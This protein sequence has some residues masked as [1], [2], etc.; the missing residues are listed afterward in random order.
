[1]AA[2]GLA[3][4]CGFAPGLP[5][6]GVLGGPSVASAAPALLCGLDPPRGA[7]PAADPL[8]SALPLIAAAAGL[9]AGASKGS[10]GQGRRARRCRRG[11]AAHEAA[12]L[13][14]EQ[15][16]APS[17][18][19]PRTAARRHVAPNPI[20]VSLWHDVDLQPKDWLDQLTGLL[21]YVNE[22]P[23]GTLQK[24]E[25]Q[26]GEPMN[27]ITEDPK[28][29]SRL[30]AFGQPVP[31]NYGCFPQTYRDPSQVDEIYAAPGDDDPLDVLDLGMTE[32]GVGVVVRCRPLGAVCLIDEGEADW[33]I[34]AVNVDQPG[35]LA[36][37]RS[38]EDVESIFPGRVAQVL[39]WIADFKASSG[40][41]TATLH[42]K[43]H[44]AEFAMKLIQEDHASWRRL[45]A[46]AGPDGRARGHWVRA[47]EPPPQAVDLGWAFPSTAHASERR[48]ANWR[49]STQS[50]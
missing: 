50:S 48:Q 43:V 5:A 24:F 25:V 36:A 23:L 45:L 1:M 28:G 11:Q 32:V 39:G 20:G 17:R 46:Q 7:A 13:P 21:H 22:M 29:S 35:P 14:S 3:A 2:R 18:P 38:V 33:K 27:A 49:T 44:S 42:H 30:A 9:S 4:R 15:H 10:A 16:L 47:P 12:T 41:D 40:K 26:P 6:V 34:L 37:A 19:L 8:A 31:F